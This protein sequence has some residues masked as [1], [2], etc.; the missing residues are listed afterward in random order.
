MGMMFEGMP[1]QRGER[2]GRG[3]MPMFPNMPMIPGQG[4]MMLLGGNGRLGVTFITLDEQVAAEREVEQTDGALIVSVIE[5]SP[6]AEAGLLEN[7]VV[8]AV[9][10]EPVDVERTLR[11]RLF[12]YEPYDVVTLDVIRDGETQQIE[13][14]LG[15]PEM[16]AFIPFSGMFE[17][18]G[19]GMFRFFNPE[20]M[21]P[22][23]HPPIDGSDTATRP[24]V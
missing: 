24:N 20:D 11:D 21:L 14:T 3:Q 23:G 7:D 2:G 10:G 17:G 9:N 5:G 15:Q 4:G 12:A 22:P 18:R 8:T 13:V 19:D 6:A 16:S 1:G